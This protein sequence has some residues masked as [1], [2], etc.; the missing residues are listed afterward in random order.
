MFK[1]SEKK[2]SLDFLKVISLIVTTVSAASLR[3]VNPDEMTFYSGASFTC[4]DGSHTM[5]ISL[6]NDGYCDCE[7]GSD[8][9]GSISLC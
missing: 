3:G 2:M 9:P 8:E 7:D 4:R 5:P 1:H 6:V